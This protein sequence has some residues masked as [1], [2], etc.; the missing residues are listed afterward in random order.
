MLTITGATSS[1]LSSV[2]LCNV[3]C[4]ISALLNASVTT[5]NYGSSVSFA[6]FYLCKEMCPT[7]LQE[8]RTNIK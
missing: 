5:S 1:C 7:R 8:A 4:N 2:Y 3:F 6:L